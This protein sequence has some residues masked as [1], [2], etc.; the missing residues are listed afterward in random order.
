MDGRMCQVQARALHDKLLQSSPKRCTAGP[1]AVEGLI[2]ATDAPMDANVHADGT[3]SQGS[4]ERGTDARHGQATVS[5][6]TRATWAYFPGG[7][8]TL[9]T[10]YV[11]NLE[12]SERKREPCRSYHE[13]AYLDAY[14]RM[15]RLLFVPSSSQVLTTL[16]RPLPRVLLSPPA[17]GRSTG[18]ASHVEWKCTQLPNGMAGS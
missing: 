17:I 12:G 5:R 15:L 4:R 8:P 18:S 16:L 11:R 10:P 14:Q 6:V 2:C 13:R 1:K 3:L 7:C 9:G